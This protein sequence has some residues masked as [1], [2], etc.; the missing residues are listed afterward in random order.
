MQRL[1]LTVPE[2]IYSF[3]HPSILTR[4][5]IQWAGSTGLKAGDSQV[6]SQSIIEKYFQS[7]ISSPYL[8]HVPSSSVSWMLPH[9]EY[10]NKAEGDIKKDLRSTATYIIANFEVT[11]VWAL[12]GKICCSVTDKIQQT[13]QANQQLYQRYANDLSVIQLRCKR[14]ISSVVYWYAEPQW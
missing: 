4:R 12:M 2:K 13:L 14:L 3:I 10:K 7:A 6:C 5:G 9:E 11:R 8:L 1:A